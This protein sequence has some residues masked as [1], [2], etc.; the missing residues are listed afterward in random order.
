MKISAKIRDQ[1]HR[2]Q[3]K[4]R[5]SKEMSVA[6]N[7]QDEL[8]TI[9]QPILKEATS[10]QDWHQQLAS[11]GI[12]YE[13]KRSGSIFTIRPHDQE[14]LTFKASLFCNKQVTL[15]NLENRWGVYTSSR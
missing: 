11:S 12:S 5:L 9:I 7:Y 8:E 4:S 10:W 2:H 3:Q 14:S 15:K 1:E 13:R 6:S